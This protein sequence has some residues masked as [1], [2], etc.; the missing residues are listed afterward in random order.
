MTFILYVLLVVLNVILTTDIKM[1]LMILSKL[2]P[3][4]RDILIVS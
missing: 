1:F 4:I 2:M 3:N